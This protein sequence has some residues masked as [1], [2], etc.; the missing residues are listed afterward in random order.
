MPPTSANVAAA[1]PKMGRI[2]TYSGISI[3]L[4]NPQPENIAIEDIA[5][6]LALTCRWKGHLKCFYSVAEHSI[7]ASFLA[8]PQHRLWA[9]LHDASEAYL[10]DIPRPVKHLA[11]MHGY[12]EAEAR[13]QAAICERFGLPEE[14]PAAV[15]NIDGFLLAIEARDLIDP[16]HSEWTRHKER[17]ERAGLTSQ[18]PVSETMDWKTAEAL[19]LATFEQLKGG[20]SHAAAH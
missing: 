2:R 4:L 3:D 13:M 1:A 19:F 17:I 18:I 15:H 14:M 11:I 8:Q 6:A 16:T 10:C 9:L 20:R 7:R 12:R 5:H